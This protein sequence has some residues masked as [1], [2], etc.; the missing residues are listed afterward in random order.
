MVNGTPGKWGITILIGLTY[1]NY[2][3]E[4]FAAYIDSGFGLCLA[5]PDCFPQEYHENLTGIQGKD[6]SNKDIILQKGI[7]N[8]KILIDKYIVKLPFIYFHTTGCDILLGNNVLQLFKT[9]IQNNVSHYLLFKTPYNHWII[10]PRL[11][12]AFKK[13]L[14][15]IYLATSVVISLYLEIFLTD[16]L[17][18][19]KCYFEPCL[20]QVLSTFCVLI[21]IINPI[22]TLRSLLFC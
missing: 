20:F 21:S 13:L 17:V 7:R 16:W 3:E 6:I 2:K 12:R 8:H 18:L 5:K 14:F 22:C 19:K 11:K 4:P 1:P 9:I 15:L 10:A